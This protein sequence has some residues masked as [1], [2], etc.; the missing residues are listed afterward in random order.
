MV[1]YIIIIINT[2][3]YVM[4]IYI[5]KHCSHIVFKK[6][7]FIIHLLLLLNVFI[8]DFVIILYNYIY[9]YIY[10][11]IVYYCICIII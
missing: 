2:Y 7:I 5:F 3:Y 4:F 1:W 11:Y 6:I 10:L 9:I 8:S